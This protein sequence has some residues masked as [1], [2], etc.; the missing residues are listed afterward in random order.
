[1]NVHNGG[2]GAGVPDEKSGYVNADPPTGK[3]GN[4]KCEL[5]VGI[6]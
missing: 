1:M 3:D 4:S 2:V 5:E 6:C